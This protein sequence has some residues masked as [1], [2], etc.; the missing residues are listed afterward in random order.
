MIM[1]QPSPTPNRP[2]RGALASLSLAM[3][4]SS[5]GLSV[6]NVALPSLAPAFHASFPA[7]QWVVLAY[8]L[9]VTAL[10]VG[11]GRL[12]DLVG[13]RRLL[14]IGVA[15]FTGASALCGIAPTLGWLASARAVQGLGAAIMM[16]LATALAGPIVPKARLGAAMGLLG[17][18]SAVGTALG[19]SLGGLLIS[20]FGWRAI[21]IVNVPLGLATWLLARFHLPA[22]RATTANPRANFDFAGLALLAASL[23][24]YALAMTLGR[25]SLGV[26]NGALLVL[27][28][29]AAA[30]FL[31][32]ERRV[33]SPLVRLELFR[34]PGF[35][36]SLA[37]SGLVSIVMMGT[38]VVGPF[39]LSRALG[40]DAAGVGLVLSVGPL[41]AAATGVPAGRLVD[42]LGARG[43][44]LGGLIGIATG[45]SAL[46]L[47]PLRAGLAGY[48]SPIVVLTASYALFQ[49][50]NNTAVLAGVGPE[51]RG[52]VSGLL[53][54]SRNLGL[55]T[56]AAV[57]GALFAH[58]TSGDVA[59]A[60][61][62]AIATGTRVTF[63]VAALL[64]LTA[65]AL[66]ASGRSRAARFQLG[67]AR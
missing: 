53:N 12:G 11:V 50:A 64:M 30:G 66:A 1:T 42:R 14:L 39:Y 6:A 38:L 63:G 49:T 67:V 35:A 51:R 2:A 4:L 10:I 60:S 54:L 59:T 7:V 28:I 65:L 19:P 37:L 21:F 15:L 27:S 23:A 8:L 52:V 56:G 31:L 24:A 3:L 46:A 44:T 26:R 58:A 36:R 45:C 34:D 41:V 47:L 57:L 13:P 18:M 29:A 20:G 9:A 61:P 32:V 22:D 40:L 25:G 17:T 33:A 43:M 55:V 62:E 5:L 16:A 48:L